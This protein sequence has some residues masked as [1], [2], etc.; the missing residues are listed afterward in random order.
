MLWGGLWCCEEG[1]GVVGRAA[2]LWGGLWCWGEGCGVG[3][4]AVVLGGGLRC[5]GEGCGV[6]GRAVVLG[7]GLRCCGEGCGV[8]GRAVVLKLTPF[9][10]AGAVKPGGYFTHTR[11]VKR[12]DPLD[13][14]Q[15]SVSDMEM[16][17]LMSPL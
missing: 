8:V 15:G 4:R 17:D 3:G 14:F 11:L 9:C 13:K 2:V 10:G 5:W 12:R 16:H 1:C 7:G 6:G